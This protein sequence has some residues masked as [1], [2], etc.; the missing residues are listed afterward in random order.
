[1]KIKRK[2][3]VLA[4]RRLVSLLSIGLSTTCMAVSGSAYGPRTCLMVFADKPHSSAADEIIR[5]AG[6]LTFEGL[7]TEQTAQA[8]RFVRVMDLREVEDKTFDEETYR[9]AAHWWSA[10]YP[11][12]DFWRLPYPSQHL[13]N[14]IWRDLQRSERIERIDFVYVSLA[15]DS[16]D[17]SRRVTLFYKRSA[18][19][20][21][22]HDLG[23]PPVLVRIY[24]PMGI[25]DGVRSLIDSVLPETNSLPQPAFNVY[26]A[27]GN[28][29]RGWMCYAG[30]NIT[31]DL[32]SS[33]DDESPNSSLTY[34]IS[35]GGSNCAPNKSEAHTSSKKLSMA[36]PD[37]GFFSVMLSVCDGHKWKDT[38]A[39]FA[40]IPRPSVVLLRTPPSRLKKGSLSDKRGAKY[41]LSDTLKIAVKFMRWPEWGVQ[42]DHVIKQSE[43][44]SIIVKPIVPPD[45][46]E[47]RGDHSRDFW[48]SGIISPGEHTIDF[49]PLSTDSMEGLRQ[50]FRF[51]YVY[52][53]ALSLSARIE[54]LAP[55][56][57]GGDSSRRNDDADGHT[58]GLGLRL[59]V[60]D[61]LS[62]EPMVSLFHSFSKST[63]PR[64][65][66]HTYGGICSEA[67]ELFASF[68]WRQMDTEKSVTQ[69]RWGWGL[70]GGVWL[71]N[72]LRLESGCEYY[73]GA[74]G[75]SPKVVI[76][77]G[78]VLGID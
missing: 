30:D 48:I 22:I 40:V 6:S 19:L 73:F 20:H 76:G 75:L 38:V 70:L 18:A 14:I 3:E 32:G 39:H 17:P 35:I 12:S 46:L 37:T 36:F 9:K 24:H 66:V 8:R 23:E 42:F 68:N 72:W 31:I 60:F 77:I 45:S 10:R 63:T 57:L 11:Q 2:V 1:M 16:S 59:Q 34:K 28:G 54:S 33:S 62:I 21:E 52:R 67:L 7:R 27:V 26:G 41:E 71:C 78:L 44:D 53:P 61:F 43:D 13:L 56:S 51:E 64:L 55:Y 50:R 74:T 15:A 58:L 4:V 65:S 49:F 47:T 25:R 5:Q 69:Q 29:R